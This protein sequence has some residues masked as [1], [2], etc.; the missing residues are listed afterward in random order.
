M[1]YT[2]IKKEQ[3]TK[4]KGKEE[5]KCKYHI[6][7]NGTACM[8]I[9]WPSLAYPIVYDAEIDHDLSQHNWYV[10]KSGYAHNHNI[11]MHQQVYQLHGITNEEKRTIDHINGYKLDNRKLNLRLATQ[12]EQNAN[13]PT[14][15]DKVEPCQELKEAG[16]TELPR[17]VR[18]DRTE[19]KF[20]IDKHPYLL[21]KVEDGLCKKPF[22]SGSK[23]KTLSITQ[24]YQDIL[25]RL[26]ELDSH[27]MNPEQVE[28]NRTKEQLTK[29]YEAICRCIKVY[30]G[31]AIDDVETDN[32]QQ[33][34]DITP[35]RRTEKGKKT[36]TK[37]P[38]DCGVNH[39]DIPKYCYYKEASETRGDKFII[40][41]HPALLAQ[42]KRQWSTTE[43]S[44]ATTRE[45][46]DLLMAKYTELETLN[47]A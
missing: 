2:I 43:K 16:L 29:E 19:Q 13:R 35:E 20:I 26:Q 38:P 4:V 14:R 31:I 25:A 45:K 24:K 27:I 9:G 36:L 12:S 44:S 40:D 22:M 15:S 6:D 18:W 21:K 11:S 41:K 10:M 33:A 42:G 28:F 8:A 1:T 5:T 17:Y 7:V 46:F 34:Q 39:A 32:I 30:E 47:N 3:L 23:S 37:L